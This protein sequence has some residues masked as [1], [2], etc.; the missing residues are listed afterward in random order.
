MMSPMKRCAKWMSQTGTRIFWT[1]KTVLKI[2]ELD[3]LHKDALMIEPK[4][5]LYLVACIVSSIIKALNLY[6]NL[7]FYY[8]IF[9]EGLFAFSLF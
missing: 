1:V 5:N 6:Q 9:S 8:F 3:I 2:S 7:G 4:L